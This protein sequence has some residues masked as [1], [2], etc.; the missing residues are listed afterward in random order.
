VGTH[1]D[2][3]SPD[4]VQKVIKAMTDKYMNKIYGLVSPIQAVSCATG[5]YFCVREGVV[6]FF[7]CF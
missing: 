7:E 5:V 2:E 6:C 1:V 4:Y 3:V